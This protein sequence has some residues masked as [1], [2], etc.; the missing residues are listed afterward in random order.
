MT[1][2]VQEVRDRLDGVFLPGATPL[3]LRAT[4]TYIL[5][6]GVAPPDRD[7]AA[8]RGQLIRLRWLAE[9]RIK[10][11]LEGSGR[12]SGPGAR[13]HEGGDPGPGR[14]LPMA[15]QTRPGALATRLAQENLDA[16]AGIREGSTDYLVRTLNEFEASRRSR[17]AIARVSAT[18]ACATWP[19]SRTR[20][21]RGGH[22]SAAGGGRDRHLREAG[23]NIVD[24][25]RR[26]AVLGSAEQEAL[27]AEYAGKARRRSR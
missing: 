18:F 5:R 16:S 8:N 14:P 27:A 12:R 23:A 20:R 10:R 21:V 3:I 24:R 13:R 9:K 7:A 26:Q 19:T 25:A 17:P 2:A 4:S 22:R 1:F 6:F 11:E 15:A